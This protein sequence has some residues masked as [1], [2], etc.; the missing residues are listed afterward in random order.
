M[1]DDTEIYDLRGLN[2]PLPV[3]KARKRLSAMQPGEQLSLETTDPLAVID[4]PAFCIE[5]GHR[6]ISSD[7]VEGGRRFLI[8]RGMAQAIAT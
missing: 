7:A 8:E 3:L 2:C 5:D 1:G 6:L 4:I